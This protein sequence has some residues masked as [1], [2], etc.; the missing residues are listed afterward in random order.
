MLLLSLAVELL[1]RHTSLLRVAWLLGVELS[2][3]PSSMASSGLPRL[4]VD[5]RRRL[6]CL[7]RVM[8]HWRLS[9]GPCL[10]ESLVAAR[11]LRRHRP[12]LVLGG[13][14]DGP[15]FVA[16]AW[17]EIGS[18]AIGYDHTFERLTDQAAAPP[19]VW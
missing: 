6:R 4:A 17:L 14:F 16:H 1:L 5:D 19:G 9:K 8:R 15:S 10:R 11:V 7:R 13:R 18:V 12:Q 2:A 3:T